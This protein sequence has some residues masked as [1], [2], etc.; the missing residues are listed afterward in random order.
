[1]TEQRI[2]TVDGAEAVASVAYRTNEVIAIYPIT[3][4]AVMGELAEEYSFQKRKNIWGQIP[5]VVEMQSEAGAI[6][7]V[8]GALQTGALSTTFTASQG[9]LLMIPNLY[10]IAG[11]LT[12]FCMHVSARTVATHAL[13]IFGDQSDVMA[14]RQTGM[15][16]LCSGSPQEAQDMA[17]LGQSTSLTARVPFIHFFDGFRTSHQID[18]LAE[19]SDDDLREMLRPE[20]VAGH[21]ERALT[22]DDPIL[23]GSSQNPDTFFQAQEARNPFYAACPDTMQSEMDRF[24]KLTGRQYHLFDYCG[25]PDAERVIVTLGSSGETIHETIDKMNKG[26]EKVGLIKVRLY[27]PFSLAHFAA[28]LPDTVKSIA[29]L[30]R[31]KEH[32]SLGEPLYMDVV[33]A[34][35]QANAQG[36][37]K[38]MPVVTGGRY[39][40]SSKEFTPQMV[41]AIFK[42]LAKDAPKPNFTVGIIDDVTHLSLEDDNDFDMGRTD[43]KR[44]VFYGLGSDGTVGANKNSI[45]IIS[46]AT[47]EYAQGYFVYDSKKAGS[48]TTSHLRFSPT[49]IQSVYLIQESDFVACH[50]WNFIGTVDV[51]ERAKTGATFLLNSPHG[52]SGTWN[53]L[54][55]PIQQEIIDKDLSV[56]VIDADK[57]AG[58]A[59]MGKRINTVMQTCFFAISDI[60][61]KDEAIGHI[62]AAIEKTYGE[63]GRKIVE[64]NFAAVDSALDHLEEMP[65]P[66]AASSAILLPPPVPEN[67]PDFVQKVTGMMLAGKGDLLPVS[68]L[69]VDGTWPVGTTQWERRN[70]ASEIPTWIPELCIQC[71]KCALVCPHA[72][73]RVKTY[74]PELLEDAPEQFISMDYK[75]KEFGEVAYTVQVAPEDCTGCTLCVKVC[76]GADKANPERLS[77]VMQP[78]PA[79]VDSERESWDFFLNLPESDRSKL[80]PNVKMSQFGQ[81]LFEFSGA[82]SGCGETP[83]IK[84][85][86]QL[87]GD[88]LMIAN[89]TGCSSIFGGNLP[90][91]PYT[92][93]ADGRGPAWANSLFEDNA[94]FGLGFRLAL[95]KHIERSRLLIA[96]LEPEL[97]SDAVNDILDAPQANEIEIFA[98]RARV[99]VLRQKL[100][101]M[102]GPAAREME[103]FADYLVKKEI[104]IIGG[105]GWAYDIGSAGLDHV[106]ASGA[107]VN[108]LVMDT[109]VYSNTGGQQSKATPMAAS[110][111]F[112]TGGKTVPKKDLG[113]MAISY[114]HVYVASVAFGTSDA[115]MTRAVQEAAS[116][117][118]PSLIIANAPCIDHGYDLGDSLGQMKLAVE[119]GY[120]LLYR[121]DPRHADAGKQPLQLDSKPA[122][123][124]LNDYFKNENRFMKLERSD[125][126]NYATLLAGAEAESF[127][128]RAMFEGLAQ[129]MPAAVEEAAEVESATP[130]PAAAA[131]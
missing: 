70:L 3:P 113:L 85:I 36:I 69:P 21:R 101:D 64:M 63:K 86:T 26:G 1:M 90:T 60:M 52:A 18:R 117:E 93:N 6:G 74:D 48:T 30:D 40:L 125:P 112:V 109:E 20:L 83:Y 79:L 128:R 76:P 43:L 7:T 71:N 92:T 72:A 41:S 2:I 126:E 50:Q 56:Y 38:H 77:L 27:R 59:G 49:P 84:L 24:A 130:S 106:L 61:P 11:E 91:T 47:G 111:K 46:E 102:D 120:W 95:D 57:V 123:I 82:C 124:P 28:A 73:I 121:Y 12:S 116:Y 66:K 68:A 39:G 32:G 19:L 62:K 87:Y 37:I 108:I 29:V 45:K 104:W 67:A 115:Q 110:A 51:L 35:A 17:L 122:S 14:C 54:P 81:P 55:G 97:G 100:K 31:T 131:E 5:D 89:A 119:S 9:L 78:Q 15:A 23:R 4:S 53:A 65:V 103:Q 22:P 42:E 88:R 80:R 58:D 94:E 107:N 25:A 44:A 8:H 34:L 98:Q 114:G 96:G 13:S 10:K 99:E 105:D 129:I 127:R 33:T 16:M 118:G 75:A